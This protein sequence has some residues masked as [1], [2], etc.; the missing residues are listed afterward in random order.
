MFDFSLL[1]SDTSA[2]LFQKRH[3]TVKRRER[4]SSDVPPDR[5]SDVF[6]DVK[7][8]NTLA[9]QRLVGLHHPFT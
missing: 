5:R 8:A 2:G 6:I 1:L 4:V 3:T 9:R 7:L